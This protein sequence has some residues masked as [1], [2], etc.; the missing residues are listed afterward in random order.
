V[1]SRRS[2]SSSAVTAASVNGDAVQP[3]IASPPAQST[4]QSIHP[5]IR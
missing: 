1:R 4:H 5:S 2:T 3:R